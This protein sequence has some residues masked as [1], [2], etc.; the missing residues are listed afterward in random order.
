M[1]LRL[2]AEKRQHENVFRSEKSLD[3]GYILAQE[4]I[5]RDGP[6]EISCPGLLHEN[7]VF[8]LAVFSPWFLHNLFLAASIIF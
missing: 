8:P 5:G 3:V 2:I 1:K 6:D 7:A 4:L